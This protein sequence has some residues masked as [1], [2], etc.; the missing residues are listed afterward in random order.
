[1]QNAKNGD[2]LDGNRDAFR[3]VFTPTSKIVRENERV[4]NREPE[5]D[6][7]DINVVSLHIVVEPNVL[8]NL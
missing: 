8:Y 1:M 5:E 2:L 3:E 6:D 7:L 4:R